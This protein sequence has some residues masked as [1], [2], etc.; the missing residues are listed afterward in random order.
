MK[1]GQDIAVNIR[2]LYS[3]FSAME[4]KDQVCLQQTAMSQRTMSPYTG[5]HWVVENVVS[6]SLQFIVKFLKDLDI[7][8]QVRNLK[9][10]T[11]ILKLQ[12][13]F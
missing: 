8:R 9:K 10:T 2:S 3:P 5:Y 12:D 6:S 7:S 4:E 13:M 1:V 11:K